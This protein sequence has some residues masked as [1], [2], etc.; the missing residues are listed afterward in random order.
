[1]EI[2]IEQRPSVARLGELCNTGNVEY[3]S[4]AVESNGIGFLTG[5]SRQSA[6]TLCFARR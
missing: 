3:R 2:K 6:L 4:A 1:M 5:K